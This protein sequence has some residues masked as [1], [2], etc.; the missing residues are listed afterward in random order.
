MVDKKKVVVEGLY[1]FPTFRT[2]FFSLLYLYRRGLASDLEFAHCRR[3][4]VT[5]W[6]YSVQCV[7]TLFLGERCIYELETK[8]YAQNVTTRGTLRLENG[9][10]LK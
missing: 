10:R 4:T 8:Q 3:V 9:Q 2:L 7:P 5:L 1:I 6:D